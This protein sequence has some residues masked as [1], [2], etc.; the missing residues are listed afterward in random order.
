MTCDIGPNSGL[1]FATHKS[2]KVLKLTNGCFSPRSSSTLDRALI[3][4]GVLMRMVGKKGLTHQA[5]RP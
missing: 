1:L 4:L 3:G 5:P 2:K